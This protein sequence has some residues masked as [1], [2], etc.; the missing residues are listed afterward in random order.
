MG[1]HCTETARQLSGISLQDTGGKLAFHIH[2][3]P[4]IP[5]VGSSLF[6]CT[7]LEFLL[8]PEVVPAFV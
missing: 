5:L 2:Y 6:F 3:A 7:P 1:N 8:S 4:Q